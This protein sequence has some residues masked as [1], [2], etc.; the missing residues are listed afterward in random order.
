L[1]AFLISRRLAS[2]DSFSGKVVVITGASRGLGLAPARRLAREQARLAI[3]AREA[4]E[5]GRAK[6]DLLK[7]CP[8]VTTWRCDIKDELDVQST[9]QNIAK[10]FGG[11]DMLINNAGEI[12]AGPLH[13]MTRKDFRN[14]LDIHFWAP[15]STT[16][17][18]LPYLREDCATRIVN[19]TSFG[20]KLAVPHLAPYCVSKFALSGFSDVL[21]AELASKNIFVTTVA[22]GL[23]RTGSHKNAFFKGDYE[24]EFTWFSLAA[25]NPLI[26]MGADR[27][28]RQILTAVR[29]KKPQLTITLVARSAIILQAIF[30]N[31]MA[32]I[33]K[34]VARL[35]PQP[36]A[37]V[38]NEIRNGWDSA[39]SF[40]LL[41]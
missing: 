23:M 19:I 36:S 6:S 2:L 18:A 25:G 1:A 12:V 13:S 28:A 35:F 26:S 4:H 20:G 11:I 15:L 27:A 22:P 38:P 34:L 29:Q 30:P 17:A 31:L 3:I 10:H 24:K 40:L 16:I 5:L 21:R 9:M 33:V 8:V 32:R 41:F 14:A 7:Y 37:Y 39:S